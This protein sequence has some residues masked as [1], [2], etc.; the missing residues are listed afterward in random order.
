MRMNF[1]LFSR[2][3]RRNSGF[4]LLEALV[5][6]I[7]VGVLTAIVAPNFIGFQI[8]QRLSDAQIT[9]VRSLSTAQSNAK[10]EKRSWQV[11]FRN[12]PDGRNAQFAVVSTLPGVPDDDARYANVPWQDLPANVLIADTGVPSTKNLIDGGGGVFVSKYDSRGVRE[13]EFNNGGVD[14]GTTADGDGDGERLV[15]RHQPESG[16]RRCIA[17]QTIL[18]ALRVRS[19]GEQGCINN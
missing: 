12:R 5:V 18:G 10:K 6:L 1:R 13:A 17:R 16:R 9:V 3:R 19:Q 2:N 11:R 15:L 14:V 7:I 4:T 8:N